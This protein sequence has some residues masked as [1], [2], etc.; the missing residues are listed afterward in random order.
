MSN[1]Q[2][3]THNINKAQ[4]QRIAENDIKTQILDSPGFSK[5][6]NLYTQIMSD[7]LQNNM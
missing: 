4:R 7:R 6:A 5:T 3:F 2:Q 1:K